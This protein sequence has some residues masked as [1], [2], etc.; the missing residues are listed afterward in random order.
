M[1]LRKDDNLLFRSYG[2]MEN[3]YSILVPREHKL[4]GPIVS[5]HQNKTLSSKTSSVREKFWI[6]RLGV[7]IKKVT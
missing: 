3:Y 6:P 5:H 4:V 7:L 1:E 2:Q